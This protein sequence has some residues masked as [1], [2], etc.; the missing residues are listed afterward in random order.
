MSTPDCALERRRFAGPL[1]D[2]E[3]VLC[4]P[5]RTADPPSRQAE[6]AWQA[7]GAHLGSL[8][9]AA[10]VIREAIF[11]RDVAR[12]LPVVLAARERA[13]GAV[14]GRFP[15]PAIVGQAPVDGAAVEIAASF[16]VARR[17]GD[18]ELRDTAVGTPCRCEGCARSGARLVRFGGETSLRAVNLHGVGEDPGAEALDMFRGAARLLAS[19]GLGFRD[20]VRTWIHLRDIDR[21]YDAMNAARRAFFAEAGVELRPAST[22]VA[23]EPCAAPHRV[24]LGLLAVSPAG[25]RATGMSTPSLNEAWSYGADFSRGLRVP[26]AAATALEVSG[27]ASIDERG[28]TV[29][30]GDL[31]AQASRMLD[32]IESLLAA[33]GACFDDV[34]SAIAYLPRPAD[35]P[36]LR[37]L[38]RRRGFAGFPCTLVTA[39]LCRPDLLC[40]T[41]ALALLPPGPDPA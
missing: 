30:P 4:R 7:L 9:D 25:A 5:L 18:R 38:F 39:R 13:L 12:D 35:A 21:D 6:A 3:A 16:L 26:G 14:A 10:E 24:A 36:A 33:Q 11:L 1:A 19:C 37:A 34:H 17:G 15:R 28:A 32:N 2:D 41:E 40:E 23:G 22:G 20:V 31:A 29:H 27:T 8:G